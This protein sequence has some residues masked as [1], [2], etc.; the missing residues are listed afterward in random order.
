MV[1]ENQGP[2]YDSR[3]PQNARGRETLFQITIILFKNCKF[4]LWIYLLPSG[5]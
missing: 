3:L 1:K 4:H 2:K 5:K